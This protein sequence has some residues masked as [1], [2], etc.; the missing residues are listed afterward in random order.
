M[1]QKEQRLGECLRYLEDTGDLEGC[2]RL[3]PDLRPEIDAQM[4]VVEK[5]SAAKAPPVDAA[6]QISSRRQVLSSLSYQPAA[7]DRSRGIFSRRFLAPLAAIVLLAA[8]A[9]A[10]GAAAG[11]ADRPG[12]VNDILSSVGV[13]SKAPPEQASDEHGSDV[14]DGVQ[15]TID[16][17]P[18]GPQRGVDVSETACEAA[19]DRTSLP[20]SAQS[21]PGQEEGDPKDCAHPANGTEPAVGGTVPDDVPPADRGRPETTPGKPAD[22]PTPESGQ[23]S[24]LPPSEPGKSATEPPHGPPIDP[25]GSEDKP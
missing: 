22:L 4:A 7:S 13:V 18:P 1:K 3:Y 23:P 16:G 10:G 6:A 24:D 17:T 2:V 8:G 12:M 15:D 11:E 19:H 5:L 25:P 9:A 20:E 14:S 21:A